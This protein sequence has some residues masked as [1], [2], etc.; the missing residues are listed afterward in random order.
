[1]ALTNS[2]AQLLLVPRDFGFYGFAAE[3]N[4]FYINENFPKIWASD[5]VEVVK[6]T[7]AQKMS[8]VEGAVNYTGHVHYD[9]LYAN[10]KQHFHSF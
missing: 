4:V 7:S 2:L 3:Q 1:M 10:C 6:L 5:L 9:S 8:D